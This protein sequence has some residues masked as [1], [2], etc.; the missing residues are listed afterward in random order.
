M[1]TITFIKNSL[2]LSLKIIYLILPSS[3]I[4]LIFC[5][6][7]V[8]FVSVFSSQRMKFLIILSIFLMIFP[9][10]DLSNYVFHKNLFL[11]YIIHHHRQC[12]IC[13]SNHQILMK[14]SIVRFQFCIKSF[15]FNTRKE[16]FSR[17]ILISLKLLD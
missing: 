9:F 6:K 3:F 12:Y 10:L 16:A 14:F 15:F 5:L 8:I 7:I 11:D 1:H 2:K 17:Y 4:F 13:T